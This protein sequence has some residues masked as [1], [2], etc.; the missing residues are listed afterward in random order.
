MRDIYTRGLVQVRF[1]L[2]L[3]SCDAYLSPSSTDIVFVPTPP[4]A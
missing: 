1:G 4:G 2:R 3:V